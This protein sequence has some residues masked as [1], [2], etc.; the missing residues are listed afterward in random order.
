VDFLLLQTTRKARPARVL[1][2]LVL[3][4][5]SSA[6]GVAQSYAV[7]LLSADSAANAAAAD[8]GLKPSYPNP[9]AAL[10]AAQRLIPTLQARG[11]LA[12][13]VD[14]FRVMDTALHLHFF[15]G[16]RYRWARLST[17][18]LPP[19]ALAASGVG[20][21]AWS[22]RA[23]SPGE[24]SRATSELLAWAEDNGY[25]FAAAG[26]A[27]VRT[28]ADGG[29]SGRL[30]LNPGQRRTLDTVAVG[31]ELRIARGYLLRYLDL[32]DGAPYSERRLADV[33]RR[34]RALPFLEEARPWEVRFEPY[35]TALYLDLRERRANALNAVVGLLP[36]Q[37]ETGRLLV[38]ADVQALFQNA[39][40]LGERFSVV[41]QNLQPNSP[42]LRA[43]V[44]F[45]YIPGTPL[46][47]D[48]QFE[49]FRRDSLWQRTS[50]QAGARY[51]LGAADFIRLFFSTASSRALSVDT[52]LVRATRSLPGDGDVRTSGGGFEGAISRT[53]FP[54]APRR[55]YAARAQLG[56]GRRAVRRAEA[57][58]SMRTDGSGFRPASL[59]DSLAGEPYQARAEADAAGYWPVARWLTLKGAYA[60]GYLSGTRLFRNELFQIGGFRLLRGFD[61]QSIYARQY[62]VATVEARVPLGGASFF[63]L[64]SDNAWAETRYAGFSRSGVYNGFGAGATLETKS[65]VFSLAYALGRS[66]DESAQLRRSKIHFGYLALF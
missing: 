51:A 33:S 32:A 41:F 66:P 15:L 40:G 23:V 60:G 28:D 34:L 18:G 42:R 3:L 25:P 39:V 59:Y 56:A 47:A 53:D 27:D 13:S 26:L 16:P 30:A 58:I 31:G 7:R 44:A 6:R 50:A 35:R 1:A 48:A 4:L 9:S 20:S 54:Q 29:V 52:A 19:A 46:G 62:H 8:A 38:T 55:G 65:G 17:D 36:A 14:S 11:F 49:L 21:S 37:G 45:P 61:E 24:L 5:W 43:E 57:V 22:G 12:A 63:Y 64:F 2:L 10:D